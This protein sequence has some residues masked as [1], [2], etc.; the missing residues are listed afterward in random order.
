MFPARR[1]LIVAVAAMLAG[2]GSAAAQAAEAVFTATLD[3]AQC[4]PEPLATKATGTLELR[5]GADGKTI[6]Y[7]LTVEN[8]ANASAADVH[9][10]SPNQNG[11][12]VVRLWQGASAKKGLFSGVLAQGTFDAGDLRGPMTGAPLADL[13]EELDAGLAYV[14]VHSNDGV[15]PP[16]SGPGD[17]PLGEIRGQLKR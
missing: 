3:G 11:P 2:L 13:V 16:N 6:S 4:Q 5:V 14:N 1:I 9:L 12:S 15:D 17:F 8:L 7:K 10:G